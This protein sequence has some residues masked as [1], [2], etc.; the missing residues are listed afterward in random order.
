M[1]AKIDKKWMIKKLTEQNLHY[2]NMMEKLLDLA[3]HE[4]DAKLRAEYLKLYL[5]YG[6][7]ESDTHT[8]IW[9]LVNAV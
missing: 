1:K 6:D 3:R 4:E 9:K 7:L 5:K 8:S 2:H